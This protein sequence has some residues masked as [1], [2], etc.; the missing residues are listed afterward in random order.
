MEGNGEERRSVTLL[1]EKGSSE[2]LRSAQPRRTAVPHDQCWA[3]R[4]AHRY[5]HEVLAGVDLEYLRADRQCAAEPFG[6]RRPEPSELKNVPVNE[7]P[8]KN[9]NCTDG[10]NCQT[11]YETL[12]TTPVQVERIQVPTQ[13][14]LNPLDAKLANEASALN[15]EVQAILRKHKSV[16]QYY[17]LIG[18]QWPVH[19]NAPAFAGGQGSAPESITNKTPGDVV[20]VFLVNTTM[21]TYFQKGNQ[22]AGCLEQDNRLTDNCQT[23]STPV[24]GTESCAGCHYSAGIASGYK[25]GVDGTP[26]MLNGV[27]T[28]VYGES[29]HFGK[30]AHGDFSWLLQ[31]E[32]SYQNVGGAAVTPALK[33]TEGNPN[34]QP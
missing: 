11:W 4:D 9:G 24:V 28:P 17:E 3:C 1:Y 5:A 33:K 8:R 32:T 15:A 19:P 23:D 29:A 25:R 20:P 18:T 21:E 27:K 22:A 12:T 13:P 16:F 10:S 34:R 14:G 6:A 2:N 30:S 31:I 26:I 7:L